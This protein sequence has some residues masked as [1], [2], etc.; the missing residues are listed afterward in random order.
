MGLADVSAPQGPGTVFLPRLQISSVH[1]SM[2]A[3]VAIASCHERCSARLTLTIVCR[4]VLEAAQSRPSAAMLKL[5]TGTNFHA[6][7][8]LKGFRESSRLCMKDQC[9]IHPVFILFIVHSV[10]F[11]L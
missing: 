3:S 5:K 11:L 10:H 2:T 9:G 4:A 1:Q 6:E 8:T 7:R